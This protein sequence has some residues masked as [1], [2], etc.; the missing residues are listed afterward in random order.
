MV[1]LLAFEPF[2]VRNFIHTPDFLEAEK[3]WWKEGLWRVFDVH[4]AVGPL[5]VVVVRFGMCA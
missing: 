4:H 1:W 2:E 5:N 3:K